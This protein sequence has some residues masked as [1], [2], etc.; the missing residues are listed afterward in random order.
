MKIRPLKSHADYLAAEQLQRKVWRFPWR[1]VIPLNE[2]VVAQRIGGYVFGAFDRGRMA[3][4]CFGIPGL[5]GA[6]P[7]HY[8]RM[9]GVMPGVRDRGLGFRMKLEQ[10]RRVLAQGLDLVRWTFDPLQSRNARLNVAKLGCVIRDYLVN[11]YGDSGSRF[12]RGLETDRFV[13][14]WW[15]RSRRVTGCLAGRAAPPPGPATPLLE[16]RPTKAGWR[17]PGPVRKPSGRILSIEIPTDIDAL[18]RSDL[19]LAQAWRRRTREAFQ[20]AFR[21]GWVITGFDSAG[22]VSRYLLEK[23]PRIP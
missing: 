11:V 21:R 8:S 22:G 16:G 5:R 15:I 3:A 4:F 19:A 10:R 13:V 23:G 12:N 14:E 17:A 9:L 20:S 1:E 2:L 18:K 6:R 7:Y